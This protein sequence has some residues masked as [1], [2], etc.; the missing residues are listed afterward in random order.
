MLYSQSFQQP[1]VLKGSSLHDADLVVLQMT[2]AMHIRTQRKTTARCAY[3]HNS[4][5][6]QLRSKKTTP[7]EIILRSDAMSVT[8]EK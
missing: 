4:T 1:E 2:A 3:Y 5:N 7:A 6:P 8:G